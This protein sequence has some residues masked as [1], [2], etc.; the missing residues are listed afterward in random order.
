MCDWIKANVSFVTTMV[1]RITPRPTADDLARVE[2]GIGVRDAAPIITEPFGE[3]VIDGTFPAGHPDWSSAGATFTHDIDSNERRKLWLLN[4]SHSLLAYTGLM[5]GRE[6]VAQAMADPFCRETAQ[7]WWESALTVLEGDAEALRKYTLA[8]TERF[9]NPR[10]HHLLT[11]I[12]TDGSLKIPVRWVP[13]LAVLRARGDLPSAV[14]TGLAAYALYLQRGEVQD[15]A[16]AALLASV[17]ET[18]Q[19]TLRDMLEILA[20]QL[21]DDHE[22]LNAV[23][24]RLAELTA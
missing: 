2:A 9:D 5:R 10:I 16:A 22:L 21:L 14:V 6:T 4:G 11:Q 1:D 18:P 20:P 12:G 15:V 3:W 8:L 23:D 19:L 13:A 17:G 7:A 24:A